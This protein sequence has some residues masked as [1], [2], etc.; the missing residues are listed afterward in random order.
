M[1][2]AVVSSAKTLVEPR[3]RGVGL[4]FQ[5]YALWPHMTVYENVAFPL[6]VRGADDGAVRSKV[7]EVLRFVSLAVD[8]GRHPSELSGGEAQRVALARALVL[9]PKILLLDEPLSS[10]DEGLR[11]ELIRELKH[12]QRRLGVTTVWVTHDPEEALEVADSLALMM[13][14][15]IVQAGPAEEVYRRPV[16]LE[17]ARLLGRL[18]VLPAS[19]FSAGEG[20]SAAFRPHDSALV[21][22]PS[23]DPVRG[24][25]EEV[26]YRGRER[27]CTVRVGESTIEVPLGAGQHPSPGTVVGLRVDRSALVFF[28]P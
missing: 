14:G 21:T 25:V 6:R 7:Q 13:R 28:G 5:S 2:G 8:P 16:S 18:N 15:R 3:A 12:L 22:G 1:D 23:D 10:L 4:V 11:L 19:L 24:E 26:V 17:A 20:S 9:D 27:Y